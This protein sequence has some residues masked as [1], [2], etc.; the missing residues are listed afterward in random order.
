[1]IA[2]TRWPPF[3][4]WM[5]SR[6]V[7]GAGRGYLADL[8][9]G[10]SVVD[11]LA[12]G[13]GLHAE[14]AGRPLQWLP[15]GSVVPGDGGRRAESAVGLAVAAA[16]LAP[17][18]MDGF[19]AGLELADALHDAAALP[20][21]AEGPRARSHRLWEAPAIADGGDM[22]WDESEEP[23]TTPTPSDELPAPAAPPS[24]FVV[25]GGVDVRARMAEWR[26]QHP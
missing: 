15:A 3:M 4:A 18:E 21:D 7:R 19:L 10:G 1:M 25:E 23:A 16:L 9:L 13:L 8:G 6:I 14:R 17:P 26:P 2:G 12:D 20:G 11:A 22:A 24:S 5:T